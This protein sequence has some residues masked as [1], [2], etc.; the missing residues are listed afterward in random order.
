MVLTPVSDRV[1]AP[2]INAVHSPATF[3]TPEDA[4][5]QKAP[6]IPV[7]RCAGLT[8]LQSTLDGGERLRCDDCR[9]VVLDHDCIGLIVKPRR[10]VRADLPT[11]GDVILA[12]TPL[13]PLVATDV[14]GIREDLADSIAASC[15]AA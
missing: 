5:E 15:V 14:G 7:W 12:R 8:L 3:P 10:N 6:P 4:G 1:F 9:M 13:G 11:D 2:L